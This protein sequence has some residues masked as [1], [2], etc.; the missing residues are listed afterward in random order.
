MAQQ[1]LCHCSRQFASLGQARFELRDC[2]ISLLRAHARGTGVTN[3][4]GVGSSCCLGGVLLPRL[5][6]Q[7]RAG[8]RA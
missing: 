5:W 1:T 4:K 7:P 8:G 2:V 6:L 3:T